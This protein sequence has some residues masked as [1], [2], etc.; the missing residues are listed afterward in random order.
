MPGVPVQADPA[1]GGK[2]LETDGMGSGAPPMVTENALSRGAHDC[3]H[4]VPPAILEDIRSAL[5][6]S[7][8]NRLLGVVAV[9]SGRT[10]VLRGTI[11]SYYLK[12][13]AQTV[14][15]AVPG[16]EGVRNELDVRVGG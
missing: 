12:Q 2:A 16:V 8:Y 5:A 3:G 13:L 15:M 9:N 6:R 14:V 10:V 4:V 7:G 11:P 1:E